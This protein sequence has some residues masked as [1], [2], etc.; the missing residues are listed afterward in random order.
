MFRTSSSGRMRCEI[1]VMNVSYVPEPA[2]SA[3]RNVL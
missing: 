2:R 1:V 3:I